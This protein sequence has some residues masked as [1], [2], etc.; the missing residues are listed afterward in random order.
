M[1]QNYRTVLRLALAV[2]A[3]LATSTTGTHAQSQSKPGAPAA[4]QLML[5][6]EEKPP[7]P[8]NIV[9]VTSVAYD[10]NLGGLAG[11]DQKCQALAEAAGLPA[12]TYRA[13]L[14]TASVNAIAR[15]GAARGWVRVDGKPF[16]DTKADILAGRLFHPIRVDESGNDDNTPSG[17]SVWTGTGSDGAVDRSGDICNGWTAS[18][19]DARGV[20][21]NNDGV[22]SRSDSALRRLSWRS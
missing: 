15:L 5:L 7:E 10:G 18:G 20:C 17:S 13:W 22:T 2:L 14:S 9:F 12:N 6:S 4:V 16:A 21:G 3:V 19:V 8:P 11:A 1:K